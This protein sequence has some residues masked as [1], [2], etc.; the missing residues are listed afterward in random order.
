MT[1]AIKVPT[2]R[3]VLQEYF[4]FTGFHHMQG[5]NGQTFCIQ[6]QQRPLQGTKL[7]RGTIWIVRGAIG[8][9]FH[10]REATPALGSQQEVYIG[11]RIDA[12]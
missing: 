2:R 6:H 12:W 11:S 8:I 1:D 9:E 4:V 10:L 7:I 3:V 5:L